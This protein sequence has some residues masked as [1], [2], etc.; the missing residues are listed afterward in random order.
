MPPREPPPE[1]F[2]IIDHPT[3][4]VA[5]LIFFEV[6]DWALPKNDSTISDNGIAYGNPHPN[7]ELYPN[8]TLVFITPDD[9]AGW[10]RWYYAADRESQDNY[11]AD[12]SYPY[13]GLT[14]YPR[15][16]RTYIEPRAT[17]AP[18]ALGTADSVNVNATLQYEEMADS[19]GDERI[20]SLYVKVVKVFDRIPSTAVQDSYNADIQYPYGG[21]TGYPRYVRRYIVPDA[22][23]SPAALDTADSVNALAKLQYEETDD[24]TGDKYNDALNRTVVRVFDRIPS[25]AIQDTYS[26]DI[27]YP[28]GDE[29]YPRYTRSYI[30]PRSSYVADVTHATDPVDP[31]AVNISQRMMN[32]TGDKFNDALNVKVVRIYDHV[33]EASD[34]T[35]KTYGYTLKYPFGDAAYPQ[36]V[37]K[38]PVL[39]SN[40]AVAADLSACPIAGYTLLKLVDKNMVPDQEADQVVIVTR[41]YDTVPGPDQN[42]TKAT[43]EGCQIPSKFKASDEIVT[44]TGYNKEFAS[45]ALTPRTGDQLGTGKIISS[46]IGPQDRSEL[47]GQKVDVLY[48]GTVSTLSGTEFDPESGE[49]IAFSQEL[50]KASAAGTGTGIDANGQYT[51]VT[52][53]N[54]CWSV[55][56]TKKSNGLVSGRT[57]QDTMS[58]YWPAVLLAVPTFTPLYRRGN[59]DY[60]DQY[61]LDYELKDAYNGPCRVSITETWTKTA[62]VVSA[63]VIMTPTE[64]VWNGY[65]TSGRIPRCLHDALTIT[66]NTGTTHPRFP[67]LIST[68]TFAATNYL[69]W[70]A[71][72]STTKVT[73]R[74]GGYVERV[75][76]IYKP[77]T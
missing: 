45:L 27:S 14:D 11:N 47:L 26:Y 10:Y 30:I 15:Y 69:D 77:G 35:I 72:V 51:T 7:V 42:T 54:P 70:P 38:F 48:K 4:E 29:S 57:Y 33:P 19:T 66:E 58:Y 1:R 46:T 59:P 39:L 52:P 32:N 3:P 17:Y 75:I 68:Y 28:Y 62:P 49:L 23:Y 63:P 18:T 6:H 25:E 56:T 64:L 43:D 9:K 61:S 21:L 12:I 60:V 55:K 13:G 74:W 24:S 50:V 67:Y 2:P 8:H 40:Y 41:V 20:D 5:D 31:N 73:P 16:V 44:T 34:A 65:L 71:S 36:L 76:T 53:V 22:T 37:W